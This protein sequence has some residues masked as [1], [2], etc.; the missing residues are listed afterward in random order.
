MT[1]VAEPTSRPSN[2]LVDSAYWQTLNR[3]SLLRFFSL[4]QLSSGP[5]HG[6]E[7]GTQIALCCDSRPTDAMIYPMLKELATGGY[8][9]LEIAVINGRKRKVYSLSERGFEA[10]RA[11]ARAWAMVLPQIEMA[12]KEAGVEP[13]CCTTMV[14][15]ASIFGEWAMND[16]NPLGALTPLDA[17]ACCG[18]GCCDDVATAEI[19]HAQLDTIKAAVQHRYGNLAEHAADRAADPS[20]RGA[21]DVFYTEDQRAAI[22]SEAEGA[23]AGCGNPVGIADARPGETVLDLG[24][25]G[26]I[27]CF[28]AAREVGDDGYVIGI[29]MTPRMI[30]LAQKNAA[31]LETENVVFKLGHIESIPQADNTVDLV[32]SNCVIALSEKKDRVFSEIIRILKPGGR[33]VISDMVT[34]RPLPAEVKSSATEWVACV[35]GAAVKDEYLKLIADTGFTNIDVLGDQ[36]SRPDADDWQ[37]S[38]RNLTLRAFKPVS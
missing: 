22:T 9:E 1:T 34:D 13:A 30:E 25:G 17:A 24:S 20:R 3:K 18:D 4:H 26:G 5:L 15:D 7:I 8:V 38:L 23:S 14:I 19:T 12:V 2:N 16:V 35:A 10:Y 29:D 37:S 33:F 32:I 11:A 28:L 36:Q 27:D 31:D 21:S 6:Y